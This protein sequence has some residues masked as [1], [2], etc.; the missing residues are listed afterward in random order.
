MLYHY[1]KLFFS[2]LAVYLVAGPSVGKSVSSA[3]T[4]QTRVLDLLTVDSPD[5][6]LP[7]GRFDLTPILA[8]GQPA[9]GREALVARIIKTVY[10][11]SGKAAIAAELDRPA[12]PQ[13]EGLV[14]LFVNDGHE[15]RSL[16]G[17]EELT[18]VRDLEINERGTVAVFDGTRLTVAHD[19]G[20]IFSVEPGDLAPASGEEGEGVTFEQLWPISKTLNDNDEIGFLAELSDRRVGIFLAS[21][22]EIVVL[23]MAGDPIIGRPE[24]LIEDSLRGARFIL[25]DGSVV[26]RTLAGSAMILRA[27]RSGTTAVVAVGDRLDSGL[28]ISSLDLVDADD[29]G[30]I[31]LVANN[32]RLVLWETG[33]L[34]E[35]VGP[36]TRLPGFEAGPAEFRE[37]FV[38]PDGSVF[39]T[40]VVE[41][42]GGIFLWN[43]EAILKVAVDGDRTAAGESFTVSVRLPGWGYYDDRQIANFP[44]PASAFQAVFASTAGPLVW[45]QGELFSFD[46]EGLARDTTTTP[47]ISLSPVASDTAG[48]ILMQGSLCCYP[49]MLVRARD[50]GPRDYYLP[51][52]ASGD[53]HL[54]FHSRGEALNLSP[55]PAR[56]GLELFD[57]SGRLLRAPEELVFL[58]GS[59]SFTISQAARVQGHARL[60]VENGARVAFSS[61]VSLIE[62]GVTRSSV[63]I[64]QQRP[65]RQ[66]EFLFEGLASQ[67]ALALT[68]PGREPITIT[69]ELIDP[70][71]S[72]SARSEL[73]LDALQQQAAYLSEIFRPLQ[74]PG[75]GRLLLQGDGVFLVALLKQSGSRLAY[76]PSLE[77]PAPEARWG[78]VNRFP[79]EV[80]FGVVRAN[81]R[82]TIALTTDRSHRA[83]LWVRDG[84]EFVRVLPSDASPPDSG[85][86]PIYE[87]VQIRAVNEA[88]QVLFHA[89]EMGSRIRDVLLWDAGETRKLIQLGPE[90]S[91]RPSALS[92]AGLVVL[93]GPRLTF[94]DDAVE[95]VELEGPIASPSVNRRGDVAF[96]GPSS[97]NL[98][99][100]GE[101]EVVA[102]ADELP[103]IEDAD[104][105]SL[106]E[107]EVNE[108][109]Q[110]VFRAVWYKAYQTQGNGVFSSR[111][112]ELH[113]LIRSGQPLPE[114]PEWSVRSVDGFE[115]DPDGS[116]FIVVSVENAESTRTIAVVRARP[117][118]DG[119]E[120]VFVADPSL[121]IRSIFEISFGPNGMLGLHTYG[122]EDDVSAWLWDA[123]ELYPLVSVGDRVPG[124]TSEPGAFARR[125][126]YVRLLETGEVVAGLELVGGPVAGIFLG[127][128]QLQEEV[129]PI[130]VHGQFGELQY[131]SR[132]LLA[133][134]SAN[135]TSARIEFLSSSGVPAEPV[136]ILE[137]SPGSTRSLTLNAGEPLLG[138]VRIQGSPA[139]MSLLHLTVSD[140]ALLQTE[141]F[142]GAAPLRRRGR[143]SS[144]SRAFPRQDTAVALVNPF[145]RAAIV[146]LEVRDAF[147]N[148][149]SRQIELP[150]Y[151][152]ATFLHSQEAADLAGFLR[153]GSV[154]PLPFAALRITNRSFSDLP[155]H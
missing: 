31:L 90:E 99:T 106:L 59:H 105:I 135:P 65:S 112:G 91:N 23:A 56:I 78:F 28:R 119:V 130:A 39:F 88:G 38:M 72:V 94:I 4:E 36:N 75:V 55:F 74:D 146:E 92:D 53:A 145:E 47:L 128:P 35:I 22:D 109:R 6:R 7:A 48:G 66:R 141:L 140:R 14:G 89:G 104:Q 139:L 29:P 150:P 110:V 137:L 61:A 153:A 13:P 8:E 69:V 70:T 71:G 114:H 20:A 15:S 98:Y 40:G 16:P 77:R 82:G 41:P 32:H 37:A 115:L 64:P 80:R 100:D 57:S 151:A 122:Q 45:R 124:Q 143:F 18:E 144:F 132:V 123:N 155:V 54:S 120:T 138:W 3:A 19:E 17:F 79:S 95:D 149:R 117:A 67:L 33:L 126:N 76:V 102:V 87:E 2:L 142:L 50:A 43:R 26:M 148:S 10:N 73:A 49:R 11:G 111:D 108:R 147:G 34:T 136:R 127:S 121:G 93:G 63:I 12:A 24:I 60:T 83:E 25:N 133:N 103:G 52:F 131:R 97:V 116:P 125:V 51:Y 42:V 81:R 21:R 44:R 84:E 101:V 96:V 85:A 62:G 118:N 152:Q 86:G 134:R 46:L 154:F 30:R 113:T 9:P 1:L 5:P 68:N 129:V 107:S 58:P 27:G